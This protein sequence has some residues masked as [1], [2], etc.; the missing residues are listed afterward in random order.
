MIPLVEESQDRI[1]GIDPFLFVSFTCDQIVLCIDAL[2]TLRT[3]FSASA[4]SLSERTMKIQHLSLPA[5]LAVQLLRNSYKRHELMLKI[6]IVDS[7]AERRLVLEGAL[8]P[9]TLM[10]LRTAWLRASAGRQGRRIVLVF[11]NVTQI[12]AE[13]EAALWEL[14]NRG[15]R[16]PSGAAP[17]RHSLQQLVRK[18]APRESVCISPSVTKQQL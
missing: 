10:D 12:S 5:S 14:M 1:K 4:L 16:F 13:G 17:T 3:L 6:S 2:S 18:N 15:V 11:R 9:S 7:G 8:I